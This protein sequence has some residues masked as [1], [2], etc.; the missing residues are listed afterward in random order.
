MR[1]IDSP[2][3]PN[4]AIYGYLFTYPFDWLFL[5]KEDGQ[6]EWEGREQATIFIVHTV[7]YAFYMC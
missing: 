5:G 3:S 6:W 2:L 1:D 7:G 4:K